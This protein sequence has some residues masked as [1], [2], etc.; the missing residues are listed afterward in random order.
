MKNKKRTNI[1]KPIK[2]D[3]K[4]IILTIT[5]FSFLLLLAL[6]TYIKVGDVKEIVHPEKY[7]YTTCRILNIETVQLPQ[8]TRIGSGIRT[9]YI[10]DYSYKV[11]DK[12]YKGRTQ[13]DVIP[14]NYKRI[15]VKYNFENPNES[16]IE[17]E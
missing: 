15:K 2:W 4:S 1:Q 6:S 7:I 10:I 8:D 16:Y 3:R 9:I 14:D 13:I 12:E 5:L 17:I 11:F